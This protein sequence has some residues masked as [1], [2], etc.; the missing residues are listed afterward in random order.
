MIIINESFLVKP[1]DKK[2]HNDKEVNIML[3]T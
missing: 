2:N 1:L 3:S